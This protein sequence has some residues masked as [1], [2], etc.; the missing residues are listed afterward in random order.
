MFVAILLYER[1]ILSLFSG[2][3]A[4]LST[5]SLLK[6]GLGTREKT[7]GSVI[8]IAGETPAQ[9]LQFFQSFLAPL[10]SD[11]LGDDPYK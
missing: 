1:L 9:V 5:A 6:K 7:V 10:W 2:V 11:L 4:I 3:P 8:K